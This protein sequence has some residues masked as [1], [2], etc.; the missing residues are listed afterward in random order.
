MD[1]FAESLSMVDELM[2]LDIYPARELPMEGV[3]SDVLLEKVKLDAKQLLSKEAVLDR[4]KQDKKSTEILMT[5]GA[6]DVS[7]LIDPIAKILEG[8]EHE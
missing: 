7:N 6:G 8:D 1:G 4:V 3:T 5:V 2:L